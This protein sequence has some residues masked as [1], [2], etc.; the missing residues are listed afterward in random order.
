MYNPYRNA[1]N[2]YEYD[3]ELLDEYF[4]GKKGSLESSFKGSRSRARNYEM[5]I[6]A[7]NWQH[8]IDMAAL[9]YEAN[10]YPVI[11]G[12]MLEAGLNPD[13]SAVSQGSQSTDASEYNSLADVEAQL[14]ANA[15]NAAGTAIS[16]V[17]G[18]GESLKNAFASYLEYKRTQAAVDF[19]DASTYGLSL[20]NLNKEQQYFNDYILNN[21]PA[22]ELEKLTADSPLVAPDGT[23]IPVE[24][25]YISSL[26]EPDT[27][28]D[29][30][31]L[32]ED[33]AARLSRRWKSR[34]NSPEQLSRIYS[35]L[36]EY[37]QARSQYHADI[38]APG[39]SDTYIPNDDMQARTKIAYD[40]YMK[41]NKW[42]YDY[43]DN[44]SA[45][46]QASAVNAKNTFESDFYTGIDSEAAVAARNSENQYQRMYYLNADP[47][48]KATSENSLYNWDSEAAN[49]KSYLLKLANG[50]SQSSD[51]LCRTQAQSI[52]QYLSS[53][54]FMN[55][56]D[57][58][59]HF[60]F[61][62]HMNGTD[63]SSWQLY[64]KISVSGW[65]RD[66]LNIP[67]GFRGKR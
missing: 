2:P 52:Y 66:N 46:L 22:E 25:S 9:D 32:P 3:Q 47:A 65:I 51:A 59:G 56:S 43:L 55:G 11:A 13:L 44:L 49:L 63:F 23:A 4:S 14:Q 29:N 58:V 39:W 16:G 45:T 53:G 62:Y 20:D 18:A 7:M 40:I 36:A 41:S 12:Q 27:L 19:S 26:L 48:A 5:Y 10:S 21:L 60:I 15:I 35:S 54:Q 37:S 30:L 42:T 57:F 17:L 38:S 33:V 24:S 61:N 64:N 28:M 8:D 67:M 6:N 1:V 34:I 50:Y 31:G